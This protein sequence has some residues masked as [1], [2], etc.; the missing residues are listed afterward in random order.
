MLS[1]EDRNKLWGLHC[2]YA[3]ND[4][5][6]TETVGA[7]R[8][9][10]RD[11]NQGVDAGTEDYT[12]TPLGHIETLP[13]EGV[14]DLYI[15]HV[16]TSAVEDFNP[17]PQ[18]HTDTLPVTP[19]SLERSHAAALEISTSTYPIAIDLISRA[20]NSNTARTPSP[21]TTPSASDCIL[22]PLPDSA[23]SLRY[24]L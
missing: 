23:H 21:A 3:D 19:P 22:A 24:R 14:E 16:E 6:L 9:V 12:G 18:E 11:G 10:G 8:G 15:G 5:E 13:P 7:V 20:T 2:L 1:R 17:Q 4:M